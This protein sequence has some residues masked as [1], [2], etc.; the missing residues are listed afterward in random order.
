MMEAKFKNWLLSRG[1]QGAANSYPKS[2]N[3]LSGHYSK[4]TG[5]P[6]D[7]YRIRDQTKISEIAHDYSQS[8]KFSEF[9]YEQH[10]RFRAAIGRYSDFFVQSLGEGQEVESI[11]QLE[12]NDHSLDTANNFA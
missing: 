8:G 11:M 4:T 6:I 5:T 10:G 3:L 7:I 2:I 9:G 12:N 1:N